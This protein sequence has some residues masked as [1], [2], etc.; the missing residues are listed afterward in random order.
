MDI[1][2]IHELILEGADYVPPTE[3]MPD[4]F[5]QCLSVGEKE[6]VWSVGARPVGLRFNGGG[7][8]HSVGAS[9]RQIVTVCK[10]E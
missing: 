8:D 1:I 4:G 9:G 6:G 7:V 3:S 10:G 5:R 2:T